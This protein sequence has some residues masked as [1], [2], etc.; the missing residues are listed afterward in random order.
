MDQRSNFNLSRLPG[1]TL[2][3]ST[4]PSDH[5][6]LED[7]SGFI[8]HRNTDEEDEHEKIVFHVSNVSRGTSVA[9][10][11]FDVLI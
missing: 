5:F 1:N 11:L 4:D 10:D 8:P 7:E 3:V 6:D 9:R 2:S